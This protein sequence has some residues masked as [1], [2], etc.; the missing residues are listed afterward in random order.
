MQRV[1]AECGQISDKHDRADGTG[2][3]LRNNGDS[4]HCRVG[5]DHRQSTECQIG[6]GLQNA[7][8]PETG[9][10]REGARNE[11]PGKAAEQ[12][13]GESDALYDRGVLITG[14]TEV[15]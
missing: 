5:A 11:A 14:K 6:Y 3:I 15:N 10:K 8:D 4:E 7:A 2:E 1:P 9:S 12:K 13:C